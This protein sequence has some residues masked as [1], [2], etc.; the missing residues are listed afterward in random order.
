MTGRLGTLTTPYVTRYR[1]PYR[2]W[3]LVLRGA[4]G[5]APAGAPAGARAAR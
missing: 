4:G 1:G 2:S 5:L 3:L